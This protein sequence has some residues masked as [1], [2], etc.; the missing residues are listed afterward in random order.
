[1]HREKQ[2]LGKKERTLGREDV[3]LALASK[4]SRK[5]EAL[6]RVLGLRDASGVKKLREILAG[7]EEEGRVSCSG[8]RWSSAKSSIELTGTY[9]P[10]PTGIAI[11]RCDDNENGVKTVEEEDCNPALLS[12]SLWPWTQFFCLSTMGAIPM[13]ALPV[14][15]RKTANHSRQSC[16][17]FMH[18]VGCA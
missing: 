4:K 5:F 13:D 9:V 18:G 15:C 12:L 8:G 7:L 1:M 16:I 6:C 14:L 3:L 2:F 10:L 11:I 17:S